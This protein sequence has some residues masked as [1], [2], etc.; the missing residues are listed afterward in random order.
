MF[1]IQI[2]S[3]I[4]SDYYYEKQY[5][6]LWTLADKSSTIGEK[7]RLINNF[8][9]AIKNGKKKGDFTDYNALLL[10]TPNNNFDANL[11]AVQSLAD[12]LTEIK[13]MDPA[14]F[15]YNTA[16]QQITAQ[17]QGQATNLMS[18]FDGC[19]TLANWPV[20]WSWIGLLFFILYAILAIVGGICL[21]VGFDLGRY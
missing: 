3:L 11:K 20:V 8:V 2:R 14:S 15:Q 7:E 12:R 6:N 1:G 9:A 4:L 17:E 21:F 5:L 13:G 19:Y 16:I 18:V 10:R